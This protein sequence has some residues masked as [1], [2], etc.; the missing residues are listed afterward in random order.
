MFTS[1]HTGLAVYSR[2]L[3]AIVIGIFMHISTMILFESEDH[4]RFPIVK[5]IAVIVGLLLG[6]ASVIFEA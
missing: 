3:M 6:I 1:T 2:Y 4:H 5:M